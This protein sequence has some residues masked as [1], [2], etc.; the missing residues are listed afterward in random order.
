MEERTPEAPTPP[1]DPGAAVLASNPGEPAWTKG[2]ERATKVLGKVVDW[3]AGDPGN[4]WALAHGILARGKD[5]YARDGRL[6]RDV[7]VTD[8]LVWETRGEAMRPLWPVE[9]AGRR[10]EPHPGLILKNLLER[11]LGLEEPISTKPGA[12]VARSVLLEGQARWTPAAKGAPSLWGNADEAPW[13]VQSWCQ[14]QAEGGPDRVHGEGH[15]DLPVGTVA[16][17]LLGILERESEFLVDAMKTR[18]PVEKRRQG[19][20][21]YACGGAH[22][23]QGV[24]ACAARRLPEG[25]GMAERLDRLADAYLYRVPWETDLVD[26]ALSENPKLALILRNQDVKFLGHLLESLGKAE[27]NHLWTPDAEQRAVLQGAE[28]RLLAQVLRI[29]AMK[30]YDPATL[31]RLR[32]GGDKGPQ[33]LDPFQVSLDLVG[34][35]AHALYG[36]EIQEGLRQRAPG[37]SPGTP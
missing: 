12:P 16:S 36:L 31:E 2:R 18:T 3:E 11:G 20:Y 19:V 5:F 21:Q 29:S 1:P 22:L 9:K 37:G 26:R 13:L 30:G 28:A 24:M 8:H 35:A 6:A 34:D 10:V 33:S 17:D 7:L 32:A 14:A 15:P 27:R 23:F 25:H 4:A